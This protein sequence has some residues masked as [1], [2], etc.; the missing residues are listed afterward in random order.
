MKSQKSRLTLKTQKIKR[1]ICFATLFILWANIVSVHAADDLIDFESLLGFFGG[2]ASGYFLHEGAHLLAAETNGVH[3]DWQSGDN[4]QPLGFVED[5]ESN[6]QGLA[7]NSAG[8]FS[9]MISS[10][11]ILQTDLIDKNDDFVRGMMAWNVFN[12]IFYSLDYWFLGLTNKKS[13][14]FYQGDIQGIETYADKRTANIF[15][16]S[17]AA[18]AAV[19]GVRYMQ[20][21]SWA[22]DWLQSDNIHFNF[23]PYQADGFALTY[24]FTF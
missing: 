19:Q 14:H 16:L 8:M 1:I 22:P 12:T 7:L 20:T 11:F 4:N 24:S 9:Q 10:E 21:Q 5:V 17:M 18:M 2:V 6:R 23:V 15:A 3:L 13:G